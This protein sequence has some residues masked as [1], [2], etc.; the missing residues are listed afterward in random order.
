MQLETR[1]LILRHGKNGLQK[2]YI[3]THRT[4]ESGQLLDGRR[5]PASRTASKLSGR[6]CPNQKLMQLF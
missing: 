6:F 4:T 1:R 3:A 2:N 5:T